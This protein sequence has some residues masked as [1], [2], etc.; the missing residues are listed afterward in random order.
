M[1]ILDG[2]ADHDISPLW[3]TIEEL[4]KELTRNRALSVTLFS[5]VGNVKVKILPQR[6][7]E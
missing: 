7:D 2:N 1:T 6:I 4:S 5:Q 3:S